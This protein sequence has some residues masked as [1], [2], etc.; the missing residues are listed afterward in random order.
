MIEWLDNNI[1]WWYWVS[2]GAV[3]GIFELFVPT[4]V[5]LWMGV[6]AVLV[7]ITVALTG[8]SFAI[9]LLLWSLLTLVCLVLWFKFIAPKMHDRTRSGMAMEALLGKQ[10]TVLEYQLESNRGVLRFSAPL[11]GADEWR[12]ICTDAVK[13]GDKVSVQNT[14]GNDLI[15]VPLK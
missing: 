8:I 14:S 9:Q 2:F 4:F 13:P 1:T 12:F 11:L 6:S 15:V 5:L 10:A 3:L 7:G